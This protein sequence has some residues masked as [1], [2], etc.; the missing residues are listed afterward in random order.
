[1]GHSRLALDIDDKRDQNKQT[2]NGLSCTIVELQLLG[3]FIKHDIFLKEPA[4]RFTRHLIKRFF[5]L[6]QHG[7]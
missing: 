1:M 6:N 4:I 5:A 3:L 2:N 7:T